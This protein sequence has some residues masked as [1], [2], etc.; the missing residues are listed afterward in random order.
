MYRI[1]SPFLT[2]ERKARQGKVMDR[3]P[4]QCFEVD[5]LEGSSQRACM[6]ACCEDTGYGYGDVDVDV[7]DATLLCV[8]SKWRGSFCRL[9]VDG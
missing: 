3:S 7:M 1:A 4:R 5:E 8:K 9:M 2:T 6:H